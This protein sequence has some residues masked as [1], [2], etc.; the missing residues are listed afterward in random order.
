MLIGS[1]VLSASL[2]SELEASVPVGSSVLSALLFSELE[3][4]VLVEPSV[5]VGLFTTLVSSV[6]SV[7]LASE[8]EASV[9]VGS[10]VLKGS[11][12]AR[13]DESESRLTAIPSSKL[14]T[15]LWVVSLTP[16]VALTSTS[17]WL[18]TSKSAGILIS[19]KLTKLKTPDGVN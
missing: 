4:S 1:S 2:V 17:Y 12:V 8:L 10:S 11:S 9:L 15:K 7:S 13:G 16:S 5:L 14:I 19:G 6:L 3:A 18:L